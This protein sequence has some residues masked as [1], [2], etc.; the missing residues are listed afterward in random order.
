MLH[1]IHLY[2]LAKSTSANMSRFVDKCKTPPPP[3]TMALWSHV[4][5]TVDKLTIPRPPFPQTDTQRCGSPS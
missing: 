3:T 5:Q 2:D 1:T 4:Y